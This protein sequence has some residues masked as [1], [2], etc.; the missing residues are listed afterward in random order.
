MALGACGN[1]EEPKDE[2]GQQEEGGGG[3]GEQEETVSLAIKNKANFELEVEATKQLEAELKGA[4]GDL[5]WSSSAV[6]VATVDATGKVT[7][8]A[9]GEATITVKFGEKEDS[10][11]VTVKAKQEETDYGSVESPITVA[12]AKAIIDAECDANDKLTKQAIVVKGFVSKIIKEYSYSEGPSFEFNLSDGT[13]EVYVYRCLATTEAKANLSVGSEVVVKAFA[14]NYKGTK[15]MCDN[16]DTKS[17]FVSIAASTKVLASIESVAG[18]AEVTQ[19]ATVLPDSVN[20]VVVYQD[21]FKGTVHPDSIDLDTSVGGEVTATAHVGELTKTFTVTVIAPKENKF[22]EA[23]AA[24]KALSSGE[25]AE[26]YFEGVVVGT[27]GDDTFVQYEGYG[28]DVYKSPVA[29]AVGDKIGVTSTLQNYN[30]MPETKTI[31][32]VEALGKASVPEAVKITSKTVHEGLNINVLCEIE[33]QIKNLPAFAN[34]D[35]TFVVSIG[36]DDFNVFVKKA[37]Y[38]NFKTVFDTLSVGD[39]IKLS[40]AITGI[41]KTN[42]QI[43]VAATSTLEKIVHAVTDVSLDKETLSMEVGSAPQTLVATVA[44]ENATNKSV[45]WESSDPAVATVE[46]GVVTAVAQGEATITIKTVDGEFTDE[47]VVTVSAATKTMTSISVEGPDK[48]EYTEGDLLDLTGLVVTA[49]YDDQSTEVLTAGYTTSIENGAALTTA[50]TSFTVTY[51]TFTSDPIALT[52]NE[53][54]RAALPYTTTLTTDCLFEGWE[55]GAEKFGGAYPALKE[56]GKSIKITKLINPTNKVRVILNGVCNGGDSDSTVTVYGLD[57]NGDAINGASAAF[58]PKRATASNKGQIDSQAI[59]NVVMLE[60]EGITGFKVELTNRVSNYI[61]RSIRIT[62]PPVLVNSITLNHTEMALEYPGSNGELTA[63][64]LPENAELKD[65][66]WSVSEG[67]SVTVA[68]GVVTPVA[69]GQA[70]VTATAKDGS[71]KSASCVVTVSE[72]SKVL[73]SIAVTKNPDKTAYESGEIFDPTGM[74]V[75]ANYEGGSSEPITDYTYSTD[76]L[77]AG[78]TSMTI[79]YGGKTTTVAIT[80]AA[81][82]GSTVDNP[83]TIDEV[84]VASASLADKEWLAEKVYVVGEIKGYAASAPN[85]YT[86]KDTDGTEF[87]VYKSALPEG[88]RACIGDTAVFYGWVENYGGTI[89]MTSYNDSIHTDLPTTAAILTRG[90]STISL[91][92]SSSE[93]A[94][95]TFEATA[96]NAS[97]YTFTVEAKKGYEI[98]SVKFAGNAVEGKDGSYTVKVLGNSK[99]LVET[100]EEGTVAPTSVSKTI[101]DLY[102]IAKD[103]AGEEVLQ[104]NVTSIALDSVITLS[105]TGAPNCGYIGAS[106]GNPSDWRLYQAQGGNLIVTAASGYT[107]STIKVTFNVSNTGAL[108]NGDTQVKSNDVVTVNGGSITLTVGNTTSGIT[109][110]QIK[111]TAIEV[112]YTVAE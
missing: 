30:G 45:T 12:A 66:E 105:T 82:K 49:H 48:V 88:D 62:E 29:V 77:V 27:R 28:I 96:T 110:G 8:V 26:F 106:G 25:T 23:Y 57:D 35:Y 55:G 84:L 80:V 94:I 10:V 67:S 99:I 53:V 87:L 22:A 101:T 3:G 83:Y 14:K 7:A 65:V 100:I 50:N 103:A 95:V 59:D 92:S 75:T 70:T 36:S 78:A 43:G 86:L 97:E 16:G 1:K 52:V 98:S 17:Q 20:V 93:N 91:D 34:S 63:T 15:E 40:N 64:V 90:T 21:G 76:K 46:N 81:A 19:N 37:I 85:K 44:P 11:V 51:G 60:G 33:A 24:A 68:N 41:Y 13:N 72:S 89:E 32:S 102:N 61:M 4:T 112:V 73:E 47:C 18:P 107:I 2:P 69:V 109:N 108:F 56:T 9:P 5:A 71:G 74:V 111:V 39:D 79:S 58:A 42:I 31:K 54:Q 38:S 6:A 104:K